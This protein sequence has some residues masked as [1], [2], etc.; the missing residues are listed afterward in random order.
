VAKLFLDD[1]RKPTDVKNAWHNG[2][3][4]EF[5]SL[6]SW[7]IVRSYDAFV[8]FIQ[9][10]GLP[11]VVSFDH[12][13]S[14]EHYPKDELSMTKPIDYGKYTE[15]T[16]YHCAQWLVEYCLKK[17]LALPDFYVHSFNP[18]GRT[19]IIDYLLNFDRMKDIYDNAPPSNLISE[20]PKIS[21]P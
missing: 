11:T 20:G 9:T 8:Q 5:P 12:D 3:F 13:L 18:T 4:E 19:N 14:W 21:V 7:E 1:I 17:R 15:K 16:G 6:F 2:A 10:N